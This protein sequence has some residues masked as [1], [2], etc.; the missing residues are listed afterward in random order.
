MTMRKSGVEKGAVQGH[1]CYLIT[2]VFAHDVIHP[3]VF[4]LAS[5]LPFFASCAPSGIAPLTFC[6]FLW[7]DLVLCNLRAQRPVYTA[8]P[9]KLQSSWR[10]QPRT[11]QE[12]ASYSEGSTKGPFVMDPGEIF[13]P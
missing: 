8:C 11:A 6:F 3:V 2:L 13:Y 1:L 7:L 5:S 9:D 10:T 12:H 4:P